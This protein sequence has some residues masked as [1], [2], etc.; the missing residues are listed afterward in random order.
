MRTLKGV[1]IEKSIVQ[2]RLCYSKSWLDYFDTII[3][4]LFF[5]TGFVVCPLLIYIYELDYTNLS[6]NEKF[7]SIIILP[8]AI[9]F[10]IYNVFRKITELRLRKIVTEFN[11][12]LNQ[13]LILEFAKQDGFDIRRKSGYL[14]VLDKTSLINPMF[15]KTAILLVRDKI[16]YFA[17]V[18][19]SSKINIPTMISHFIFEWRMRKWLRQNPS[20]KDKI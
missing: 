5:M 10:G 3:F 8:L 11:Q 4:I 17:M 14:I 13:K 20:S 2:K 1:D 7:I 19:D 18:Q 16:I 12:D 9:L 15:A 6:P